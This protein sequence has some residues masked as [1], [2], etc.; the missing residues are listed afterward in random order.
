MGRRRLLLFFVS[1]ANLIRPAQ[2]F[3]NFPNHNF[4]PFPAASPPPRRPPP[5]HRRPETPAAP[6]RPLAARRERRACMEA[7]RASAR[8][9]RGR[10]AA[11]LRTAATRCAARRAPPRSRRSASPTPIGR[12]WR[13]YRGAGRQGGEPRWLRA[14]FWQSPFGSKDKSA[15][16]APPAKGEDVAPPFCP[17]LLLRGTFLEGRQLA[18][19]YVASRYAPPRGGGRCK[20]RAGK[21][22]GGAAGGRKGVCG[23]SRARCVA[24]LTPGRSLWGIW[25]RAARR[26]RA[27]RRAQNHFVASTKANTVSILLTWRRSVLQSPGV[28]SC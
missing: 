3:P 28:N 6:A 21:G 20:R 19:A 25:V 27:A 2:V 17:E 18:R 26:K 13:R 9:S 15:A 1:S 5:S 24:F 22:A 8:S 11:P 4:A 7:T 23:A 10:P 16:P 14:G 12:A